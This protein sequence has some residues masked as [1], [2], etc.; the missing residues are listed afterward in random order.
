MMGA[1]PKTVFP[2]GGDPKTVFPLRQ[3][4]DSD[5]QAQQGFQSKQKQ[6]QQQGSQSKKK[7]KASTRLN[8]LNH[9]GFLYS[10]K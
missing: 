2:L 6:K 3:Q 7:T 1:D 10:N 9:D 8:M 5:T 4:H